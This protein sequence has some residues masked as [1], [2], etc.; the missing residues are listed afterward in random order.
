VWISALPYVEGNLIANYSRCLESLELGILSFQT[1]F[2]LA[3][4]KG[5]LLQADFDGSRPLTDKIDRLYLWTWSWMM[6][7]KSDHLERIIIWCEHVMNLAAQQD[8]GRDDELKLRNAC[9]WLGYFCGISDQEIK[10]KIT[11]VPDHELERFPLFDFESHLLDF[12]NARKGSTSE[13]FSVIVPDE[14]NHLIGHS[15]QN[16][17]GFLLPQALNHLIPEL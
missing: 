4:L 6:D 2:R 1:T 10:S 16:I 7:P 12:L 17:R 13:S 15:A 8:L 5:R 14:L 3:T 9:R 11:F